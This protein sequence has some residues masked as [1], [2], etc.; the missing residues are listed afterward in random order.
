MSFNMND[1]DLHFTYCFKSQWMEI[2]PVPTCCKLHAHNYT[3]IPIILGRRGTLDPTGQL[4]I[5]SFSLLYLCLQC[6]EVLMT[7]VWWGLYDTLV[8]LDST[9][10][11]PGPP[12]KTKCSSHYF[13]ILHV[14]ER[15]ALVRNLFR[16]VNGT[17]KY[18]YKMFMSSV[19]PCILI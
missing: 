10:D 2:M 7:P 11:S 4:V 6:D 17:L 9:Y 19:D 16:N 15:I 18:I 14:V 5:Y 12:K 1:L 3:C 13:H 8:P